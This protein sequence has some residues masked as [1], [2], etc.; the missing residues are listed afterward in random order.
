MK[1]NKEYFDIFQN[2]LDD[3]KDSHVYPGIKDIHAHPN[4]IVISF[5]TNH[6]KL[7]NYEAVMKFSSHLLGKIYVVHGEFLTFKLDDINFQEQTITFNVEKIDMVYTYFDKLPTDVFLSILQKLD[8]DNTN[9]FV[10]GSGTMMTDDLWKTLMMRRYTAYYKDLKD[11]RYG[12]T[13]K[14]IYCNCL[15]LHDISLYDN[16]AR[17]SYMYVGEYGHL[18][19]S[20]G[21][22][23]AIVI[24]TYNISFFNYIV[25]LKIHDINWK[26]IH[27][28]INYSGSN[29]M[30]CLINVIMFC[31]VDDIDKTLRHSESQPITNYIIFC[32]LLEV[33]DNN[34]LITYAPKLLNS[35]YLHKRELFTRLPT[36]VLED[37]YNNSKFDGYTLLKSYVRI[38]LRKI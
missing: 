36:T 13:W 27:D 2:A 21:L 9:N 11:I 35:L 6:S 3:T 8:S 32:V 5:V 15:R 25:S 16:A 29:Y 1:K 31:E 34:I 20:Q 19:I 7:R 14:D 22:I 4:Q 12:T 38:L 26:D 23:Y 33:E 30:P 17:T 18:S 24:K 37:V 10:K 28:Q